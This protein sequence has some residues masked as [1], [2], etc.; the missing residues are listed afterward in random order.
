M[1][2]CTG[3]LSKLLSP[4]SERFFVSAVSASYRKLIY[5]GAGLVVFLLPLGKA[6]HGQ[7]HLLCR[8][9]DGQITLI[10]DT[11]CLKMQ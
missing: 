11:F 1:N 7:K 5:L 2:N 3:P 6:F 10:F 4:R 9:M 8:Q